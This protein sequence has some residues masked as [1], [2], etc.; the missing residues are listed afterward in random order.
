MID[1]EIR[2]KKFYPSNWEK[3]EKY[4]NSVSEIQEGDKGA[5]FGPFISVEG[6]PSYTMDL[7]TGKIKMD[8]INNV[9]FTISA[10]IFSQ[11]SMENEE[12]CKIRGQKIKEQ[13]A[14]LLKVLD[15][16]L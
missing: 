12:Y 16:C 3:V 13:R 9:T 14:G 7:Q 6:E 1:M 2:I 4:L 10:G 15:E 11:G 5:K 8:T